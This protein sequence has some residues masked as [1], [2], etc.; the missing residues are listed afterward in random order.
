MKKLNKGLD[1]IEMGCQGHCI[2][3]LHADGNNN[4]NSGCKTFKLLIFC[5]LNYD[6]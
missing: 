3:L 4:H 6:Y 5:S 1:E 2:V